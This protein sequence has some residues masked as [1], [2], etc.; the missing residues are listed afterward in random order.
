[1]SDLEPMKYEVSAVLK[2][3]ADD[4]DFAKTLEKRPSSTIEP[5]HPAAGGEQAI[6]ALRELASKS[7]DE[8][9]VVKDTLGEGGMGV[10]RLAEQRS[11]GREVA[12]K[13]LREGVR[14]PETTLRALREAWITGAIEHPNIVP[15]YDVAIGEDG[16]PVIVM[17]RIE[18]RPWGD[19]LAD[20][21]LVRGR[22]DGASNDPIEWHL[23]VLL[24]V[25]DAVHFAHSR[26]I[27]HR[28]LKP[29]NVMIGT[30][31]EVYVLDW[32]I[33]VSLAKDPTGR[34]PDL[35]TATDIA[36]TPSYMAPE[37]LM[38]QPELLSERT[39]VYLLGAMM[40]ELFSGMPPHRGENMQQV[41]ASVIES[42]L[43]FS[44]GFPAEA[45]A[46]VERA[47]ARD[48]SQRFESAQALRATIERYLQHRGSRKLAFHARKSLDRLE[49]ILST[50]PA[51]AARSASVFNLLGECRFGYRAALE[52]WPE[53]ASAR[54]G[55]DRA[56][57]AVIESELREGDAY[58]A[59]T[60][61]AEVSAKDAALQARVERAV[62][63]RQAED[64]RLRRFA[65]DYDR[66]A[67]TRT[68]MVLGVMMG[69]TWTVIPLVGAISELRGTPVTFAGIAWTM[70]VFTTVGLFF[71]V[72]ARESLG[73]TQINRGLSATMAVQLGTQVALLVAAPAMQLTPARLMALFVLTW[74]LTKLLVAV[75]IERWFLALAML[76]LLCFGLAAHVPP[77][78]LW[79]MSASNLIF[80]AAI[81]RGWLPAQD[82]AR[83]QERRAAFRE[84]T[85]KVLFGQWQSGE[86]SEE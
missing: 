74:A 28:D 16:A 31:G 65:D 84:R 47:T 8:R 79:L 83:I 67:G 45:R 27:I 14:D 2:T 42:K 7:V 37:Q 21:D 70:G 51:G 17:K 13:T 35:S 29:E 64:D 24:S 68:R 73:K 55:L 62:L 81:V 80:T 41:L 18:G 59:Q 36:G 56:L 30:F 25:C 10:V 78:T 12:V 15:V 40:Y 85:R 63:E 34:L 82:R 26:G 71:R 49:E 66:E 46:I 69:V 58:A 50:E 1:M 5:Q 4:L 57:V 44:S 9:L 52:A 75:W 3:L 39:D 33:A 60:L 32:G 86:K 48:P 20:A 11:M 22:A 53:N 54:Q 61:F 43:D 6:V 38:Q 23:R 72:W 76:D 77:S 19:F